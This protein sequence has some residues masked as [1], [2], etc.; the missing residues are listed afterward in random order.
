MSRPFGR[1]AIVAAVLIAGAG[2][3]AGG[4][5][6]RPALA[7]GGSIR[8]GPFTITNCSSN[9]PCAGYDN[10]ASGPAF[11]GETGKGTGLFGTATT[12]GTGIHGEAVSGSGVLAQSTSG[13]GVAAS[14]TSGEGLVA[15]SVSGY[16]IYGSSVDTEAGYLVSS[17]SN[18]LTSITNNDSTTS[19]VGHSGAKGYDDTTDGGQLNHGVSGDSINGIGV[20]GASTNFVGV[21]AIG[22]FQNLNTGTVYPALSIVGN[23]SCTP[24]CSTPNDLIDACPSGTGSPCDSYNTV[25]E[26]NQSGNMFIRG[27]IF[28]TGGC[29]AGC[30]AHNSVKH[31][32]R[33]YTPRETLPTVE[34]FGEAQLTA[35]RAY[36]RIDPPFADTIDQQAD[37]FV[38]IT[39]EGPSDGVYVTQK[40][41]TG[42]EVMENPGGRSNIAFQYRIVAKPYGENAPRLQRITIQ[43]PRSWRGLPGTN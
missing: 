15:S 10:T 23:T 16:G 33:F 39:P 12:T 25:L 28:T 2:I 24:S 5:S 34:D 20:E 11:E 38:F 32:V 17:D 26:L 13:A 31:G 27:E 35:G 36:V 9:F 6:L 43:L 40:S 22:G 3:L 37:Y 18:G 8:V 41:A 42:F 14:S 19:R 1:P 21:N 30:V 29:R 4:L 7:N